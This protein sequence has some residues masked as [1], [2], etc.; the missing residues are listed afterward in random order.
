MMRA[1]CMLA[2]RFNEAACNTG[3]TRPTACSARRSAVS[4][5]EAACNTGGTP[6]ANQRTSPAAMLQ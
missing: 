4:F 5:N 1:C 2:A 3:G 6:R